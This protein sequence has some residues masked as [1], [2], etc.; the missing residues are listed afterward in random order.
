[1][2]KPVIKVIFLDFGNVIATF[3]FALFIS[4]FA[5]LTGISTEV[6]SKTLRGPNHG[7]SEF[8]AQFEKGELTPTQF[9]HKFTTGLGI[10]GTISYEQ[11]ASLWS[12]IFFEEN[13]LLDALL[14]RLPQKKMIISNINAIVTSRYLGWCGLVRKHIPSPLDRIYSYR[15]GALKPDRKIYDE[16]VARAGVP[17]S[18]CLFIDDLP[19]NIDAWRALGG[20]GIVYNAQHHSIDGLEADLY[21]L[22]VHP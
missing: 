22:G 20:Y 14:S 1:M 10:A 9:F 15:V 7:Y 17:I 12:D 16:A 2:E 13:T 4:R 19:E 11:F 5:E 18:E 8:F 21:L 6:L 3:D